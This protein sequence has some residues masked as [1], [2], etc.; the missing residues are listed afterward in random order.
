[1]GEEPQVVPRRSRAIVKYAL[2]AF[3]TVLVLFAGTIAYIVA[4]FDARDYQ[5]H[6]VRLVQEKT[7]RTLELTGGVALSFW[8]DLGVQLGRASLSERGSKE[9]FAAVES[10]RVR[11]AITPL[12]S[13][14]IVASDLV[15]TG[16]N[17]LITRD[18]D[19]RLNIDD[20]LGGE[21]ATPQFDIG[22][23]T[24]ER[25]T[26]VYRDLATGTRYEVTDIELNADRL[27]NTVETPIRAAFTLHAAN[28]EVLLRARIQ[29]RLAMDLEHRSYALTRASVDVNGRVP[30]L[31]DAS[32][33]LKGDAAV[34]AGELRVDGLSATIEGK[35]ADDDLN[36]TAN[37]AKF[38]ARAD[39]ANAERVELAL[40]AKGPSGTTNVKLAVTSAQREGD[41]LD[42]TRAALELA[43]DRGHHTVR[44][45]AF[46]AVEASI[47][48]RT[49]T[50][51]ALDG[52]FSVIGPRLPRKGLA[53][54]L[55]GDASLDLRREGVRVSVAGTVAESRVKAQLT[56]AGFAAPVYTFAVQIDQLDLDRYVAA[57][58]GARPET[59]AGD[60]NLLQA[61]ADVPATGS[62]TV[63]VLKSADVKA[64][65]VRFEI[66]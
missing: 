16:A 32:A 12:L 51:R 37:A 53:G 31:R 1:M 61:L 54:T 26:I 43:A 29:A 25:S 56:A 62:V 36:L 64:A 35:R 44:T 38:A 8:P 10:A 14:E 41:R 3:V 57:E 63:G 52:S 33:Q 5:H 4:T 65:N 15:L 40:A 66:K 45:Q 60:A 22:R 49:L 11:L 2:F 48:A 39:R 24:L 23:V 20:L 21:G 28:E 55:R 47:A 34:R 50:A 30:G 13:H 7:G 46:A 59:S 6:I 19:G 17:V 18:E 27:A 58:T 9:P 42:T